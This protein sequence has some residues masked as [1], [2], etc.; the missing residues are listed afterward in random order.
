[1]LTRRYLGISHD[2]ILQT[3]DAL[4]F[5]MLDPLQFKHWTTN[6][7]Y[8][9]LFDFKRLESYFQKNDLIKSDHLNIDGI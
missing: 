8:C 1:M 3:Y 2:E 4:T 9:I 6:S 7:L 5:F